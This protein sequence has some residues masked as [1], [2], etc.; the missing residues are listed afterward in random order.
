MKISPYKLFFSSEPYSWLRFLADG[1]IG[2]IWV[3]MRLLSVICWLALGVV[4]AEKLNRFMSISFWVAV[5]FA[6]TFV[7][8][9]IWAVSI[10]WVLL[11]FPFPSCRKG[12]CCNI[13]D[14]TWGMGRIYGREKWGVYHYWCRCG[15][16]YIHKGKQFL[17]VLPDGTKR[18]YMT[19]TGFRTWKLQ[20]TCRDDA[21]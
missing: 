20:P 4:L 8:L 7:L 11:F 5:P 6:V 21:G 18:P 16:E 12:K 10:G 2:V 13:S 19:R 9:L 1:F 17:Q 3:P 14:Y 15:D